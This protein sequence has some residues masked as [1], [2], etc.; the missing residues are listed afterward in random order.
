MPRKPVDDAFVESCRVK[1]EQIKKECLVYQKE[2]DRLFDEYRTLQVLFIE[3][4]WDVKPGVIVK[5][6]HGTPYRVTHVD[7]RQWGATWERATDRPWVTGNPMRRDG[8]FG[9]GERR[10]YEHWTLEDE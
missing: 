9:R 2:L 7:I 4:V 8:T 3:T 6:Q 10:L 1:G 5:D